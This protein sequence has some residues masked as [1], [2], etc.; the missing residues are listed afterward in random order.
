MTAADE[1]R[2]CPKT[3]APAKKARRTSRSFWFSAAH[4]ITA[5]I[6]VKVCRIFRP[7]QHS[8]R[9][10]W[11][12]FLCDE[13]CTQVLISLWKSAPFLRL[14]TQFSVLCSAL[15]Y[16]WAPLL[17]PSSNFRHLL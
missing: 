1:P 9:N 4:S 5:I 2:C 16:F 17:T 15:H 13:F 12:I 14:T 8:C 3:F 6:E 7:Q 11:K 10:S